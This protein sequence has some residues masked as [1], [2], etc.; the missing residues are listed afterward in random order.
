MQTVYITIHL[1]SCVIVLQAGDVQPMYM[2][3]YSKETNS[4]SASYLHYVGVWTHN[5]ALRV[6]RLIVV[7][8]GMS[9]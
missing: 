1:G 6:W 5:V 7:S 2:H 3:C 9:H 4:S 8:T